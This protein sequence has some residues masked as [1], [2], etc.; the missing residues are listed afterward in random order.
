MFADKSTKEFVFT[1]LL[2]VSAEEIIT[3]RFDNK[4]YTVLLHR[5]DFGLAEHFVVGSQPK[6]VGLSLYFSKPALL[7]AESGVVLMVLRLSQL[8][9][10]DL[11]WLHMLFHL[12]VVKQL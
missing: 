12:M 3:A 1:M 5:D 2:V 6:D 10:W 4:V 11:L 8:S 7:A 9:S